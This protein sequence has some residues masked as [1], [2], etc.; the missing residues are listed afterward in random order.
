M[1]QASSQKPEGLNSGASIRS[2]DDISTDRMAT[3][4]KKYSNVFVDLAYLI[5]DCA[6]D[7]AERDGKY[8]TVYPN[9]DGTKEI[10]LPA[11]K[12]LK[13]PFVIQCFSESSLPRTPA[14]RIQT[15]TEQVQAGMLTIKEGRRL[16]HFPDLEQNERLDNASE[17]RIF[18][19]LDDIV[20]K[21]KYEPP[22]PFIDLQLA[23]QLTVQYIN[24][25]LAANLEEKK[26]D[27]L[28]NF[29][30][31]CQTLIQAAM[32]PPMPQPQANPEAP[33]TS[34][35]VPNSPAAQPQQAA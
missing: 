24:L 31:Q 17:E 19:I 11:M 28:R 33:P 25:Y 2:F 18:K 16:M 21:G 7:I 34:P 12:F 8:Q 26:A 15:V 27:L 30:K 1:M 14:G 3:V 9:K 22:D 6:M 35:L 5:A 29:F 13:D 4:S 10:D 23:T 32:P 20:E